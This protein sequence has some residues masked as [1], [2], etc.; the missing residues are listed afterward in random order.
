MQVLIKY[1]SKP[2]YCTPLVYDRDIIK[3]LVQKHYHAAAKHVLEHRQ[4]R[5][6]VIAELGQQMRMELKKATGCSSDSLITRHDAR[7][8]QSFAWA[9]LES[10]L[11]QHCGQLHGF[12]QLCVPRRKRKQ[13]R[14][15][16]SLVIA[17]LGKFANQKARYVET[18]LSL[19]L[20]SGHATSQVSI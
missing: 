18:V 8:L 6:L 14:G 2:V 10:D 20:L 17:M 13:A 4:L 3:S 12:L 1:P 16:L 7:S 11:I 9:S 15:I 19:M 5:G